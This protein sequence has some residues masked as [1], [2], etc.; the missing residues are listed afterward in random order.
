MNNAEIPPLILAT[1]STKELSNIMDSIQLVLIPIGSIE[2]HGPNLAL[3]ADTVLAKA[4]SIYLASRMGSHVLVAPE[5]FWGISSHHM[6]FPGTITLQESTFI[7][8]LFDLVASLK[9]HGFLRFLFINGHSGNSAGINIALNHI[10]SK[11]DLKFIGSCQYFDL[12]DKKG[13]GHAAEM[14]ISFAY[15]LEPRIVKIND[16]ADGELTCL[17]RI[18]GLDMPYMTEEYSKN[19]PSGPIGQPSA[20]LGWERL[21][22]SLTNLLIIAE[23]IC[24]GELDK[25]AK[26]TSCNEQ[27][28]GD[29]KE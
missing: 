11:L 20:A 19:G 13:A 8:L 9:H 21:E 17:Q 29:A 16:L 18:A 5:V 24:R 15:A 25:N 4:A 10:Y 1:L 6:S 12:G 2:Q 14:E 22:P 26:I 23:K 28:G 7:A 3:N 27:R